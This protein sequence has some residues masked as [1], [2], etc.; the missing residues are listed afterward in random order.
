[1]HS[2][3]KLKKE[4]KTEQRIF[5]FL[6][7][8]LVIRSASQNNIYRNATNFGRTERERG[9]IIIRFINFLVKF[10][11]KKKRRKSIRKI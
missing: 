1:M 8:I 4:K 3:W 10:E 5:F 11:K 2:D 9:G 6:S 7:F